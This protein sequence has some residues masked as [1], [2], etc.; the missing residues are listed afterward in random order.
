MEE[1]IEIKEY[2]PIPEIPKLNPKNS[3]QSFSVTGPWLASSTV[4]LTS[5]F[6]NK[7]F[8]FSTFGGS[9][10]VYSSNSFFFSFEL[11]LTLSSVFFSFNLA[12]GLL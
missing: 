6:F 4:N 12:G 5:L 11:S 7:E 1:V 9:P 8:C 3:F 10:F 2:R